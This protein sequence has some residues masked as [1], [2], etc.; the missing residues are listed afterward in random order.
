[1]GDWNVWSKLLNLALTGAQ[2]QLSIPVGRC[3]ENVKELY[4]NEWQWFCNDSGEVL[5][6][7]K[8]GCWW[9]YDFVQFHQRTRIRVK[10]FRTY[11][12]VGGPENEATLR[13][14][15]VLITGT[16]LTAE[17]YMIVS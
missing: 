6:K 8:E 16:S 1:M 17:G 4:A 3:V 5:F 11:E 14:T 2:N 13:S 15:S 9:R 12:I 7:H 10:Q